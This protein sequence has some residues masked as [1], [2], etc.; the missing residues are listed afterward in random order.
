MKLFLN[1]YSF[2]SIVQLECPDW[3]ERTS[4]PENGCRIFFTLYSLVAK[5]TGAN[6]NTNQGQDSIKKLDR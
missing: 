3:F 2:Y 5:R 4:L 6:M 1:R